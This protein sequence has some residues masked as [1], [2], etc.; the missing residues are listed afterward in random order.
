MVSMVQYN[1]ERHRGQVG[2]T[3]S[4][5]GRREAHWLDTLII[6][7]C[8]PTGLALV[9][10]DLLIAAYFYGRQ[11]GGVETATNTSA[12]GEPEVKIDISLE[13]STIKEQNTA[14]GTANSIPEGH[15]LWIIQ[16]TEVFILSE[17]LMG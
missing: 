3:I 4:E 14:E 10:L 7:R 13:N 8:L 16:G 2:K 6:T 17:C 5:P 12:A 9:I 11:S 1:H 15:Q